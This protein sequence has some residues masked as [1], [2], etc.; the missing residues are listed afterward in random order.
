MVLQK[1]LRWRYICTYIRKYKIFWKHICKENLKEMLSG[2]HC[3]KGWIPLVRIMYYREHHDKPVRASVSHLEKWISHLVHPDWLTLNVNATISIEH[4][5][6][7]D[8]GPAREI[9]AKSRSARLWF[10]TRAQIRHEIIIKYHSSESLKS[11]SWKSW[12]SLRL[13]YVSE[14]MWIPSFNH[15]RHPS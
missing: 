9:P 10:R 14:I 6:G 5:E 4:R 2:L 8:S 3:K 12:L 7:R 13:C 1:S 11:R 15:K